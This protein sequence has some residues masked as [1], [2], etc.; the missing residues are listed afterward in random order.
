MFGSDRILALDIGAS[1][2]VLAEFAALKPGGLELRSYVVAPL[3]VDPDSDADLPAHVVHAIRQVM[4]ERSI[5]PG[6][7]AMSISGQMVFP[8]YVKLPPVAKDKVAQIVRYEAQQNVPF[9]IEEVVWGYQL[10]GG[11]QSELSV[12]LVAVKTELVQKLT[13]CVEATGLEPQIVDVSPLALYN[14]VR[15]NYPDLT[16]CTMILDIGARSTNVIFSEAGRIFTRSIPVAGIAMT[17]DLMKEFEL[18]FKDAEQL[19]LSHVFVGFGG[20]YE[21]PGNS[22]A[23]RV[24]KIARSVMTRLHAEVTRTVNF[25]RSQQGGSQPSTVLLTGGS[26]IIPHTDTFLKD[27][28]KVDVDYLNPFRNVTVSNSVSAEEIGGHVQLLGEVVGLALRRT[29]SCPIEINLLPPELVSRNLFQRRL[30]FLGL[31]AAGLVVIMLVWGAYLHRNR[32]VAAEELANLKSRVAQLTAVDRKIGEI[33]KQEEDL[34]ASTRSLVG[35]I[36]QRTNWA[37]VI[38][39]IRKRMPDGMWL[40]SVEEKQNPPEAG[41]GTYLEVVGMAFSDKVKSDAIRDQFVESLRKAEGFS[42]KVEMKRLRPVTDYVNE[43]V[44]SI[45]PKAPDKT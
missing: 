18:T 1:R 28:L 20:V 7:V 13:D 30:P 14:A 31:A 44:I 5:K 26:S 39:A 29:L 45:V 24:S 6:P 38:E 17:K 21:E 9:P 23:N 25:Y 42:E 36:R 22:V 15:Y 33:Q 35:L 43:F 16:G 37:Q 11:E 3:D 2:L 41:A 4:K 8:R 19:K 27:K 32:T 40:V 10:I 12:M 34:H